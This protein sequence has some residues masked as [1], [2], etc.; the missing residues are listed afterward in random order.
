MID[1]RSEVDSF[2]MTLPAETEK[3]IVIYH[4]LHLPFWAFFRPI[5]GE[6]DPLSQPPFV[7]VEIS[8]FRL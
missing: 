6:F 8:G 5:F 4:F 1:S 7:L 2:E 3:N